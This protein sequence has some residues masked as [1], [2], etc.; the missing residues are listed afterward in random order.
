MK[1]AGYRSFVPIVAPPLAA[2][3]SYLEW[4]YPFGEPKPYVAPCAR[5]DGR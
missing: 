1:A 4:Q 2:R 3:K 5:I